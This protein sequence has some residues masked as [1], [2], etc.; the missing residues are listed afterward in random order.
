MTRNETSRAA[1]RKSSFCNGAD[2]CVEV[3]PLPGG[4]VGVRDSKE[5]DGA[6]L[7]FSRPEFAAFVAGVRAGEY[8]DLAGD[9]SG[10]AARSRAAGASLAAL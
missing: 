8:D 10:E 1:W 6:V 7:L 5:Q 4:Y 2:A 3:A 9:G